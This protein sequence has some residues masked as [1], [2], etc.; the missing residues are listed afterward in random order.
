MNIGRHFFSNHRTP[1]RVH[2]NDKEAIQQISDKL[3]ELIKPN[4]I[5][6][7]VVVCIGTDRSTGDSL[8]P[9]IGSKLNEHSLAT[10]HVYGNLEH[11]V[12]ALN[13]EET[14]THIHERFQKPLIIGVDACLGKIESVGHI[15]VGSGPI[16]PGTAVKKKLPDVGEVH[17]TGIVNV[18]GMM[19]YFVLQNTRL[20]TVMNLATIIAESIANVDH[21]LTLEKGKRKSIFEAMKSPAIFIKE[22]KETPL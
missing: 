19:E 10:M 21:T 14:L 12:H 9:L 17:L 8:G 1:L 16:K 13:L 7:V 20:F 18:G 3:Y 2:M 11:P 15:T 4:K 5:R 22:R 6:E